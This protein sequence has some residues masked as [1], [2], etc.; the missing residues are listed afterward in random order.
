MPVEDPIAVTR[1]WV[2]DFVIGLNLCPFAKKPFDAGRIRFV[3]TDVEGEGDLLE[4]LDMELKLLATSPREAI[5]T[6]ILIHPRALLDFLDYN[7]FL[8][9]AN[10]RLKNLGYAG[11]IQ[12]ASFHPRYQ[13]ADTTPDDVTNYTNRSRY[14]MLHLLREESITEVA[15]NPEVL[16]GIPGRNVELLRNMRPETVRRLTRTST[17]PS[18]PGS[19]D[20]IPGPSR[21][22]PG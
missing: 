20:P 6:T 11:V 14:P 7:D 3:A 5:E 10:R 21:S 22:T 13:F 18:A 16:A 8:H 1:Q 12:I 9:A 15:G 2:R 17:A 4:V 19:A